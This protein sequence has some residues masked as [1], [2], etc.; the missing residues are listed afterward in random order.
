[1]PN[2]M[3]S[4]CPVA[5]VIVDCNKCGIYA[6]YFRLGMLEV[7][8]D[9]PLPLLLT[10]IVRR[11]GCTIKEAVDAY[12][13]YGAIY[14]NILPEKAAAEPNAYVKAKGGT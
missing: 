7:G 2:G 8:G 10:E 11:K 9:R 14:S 6:Q 12:N 13:K 4:G 5:K 1:M 3:L